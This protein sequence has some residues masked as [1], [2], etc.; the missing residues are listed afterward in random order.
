LVVVKRYPNRKL[1]NTAAKRYVSLDILADLIRQGED[2]QVLDHVTGD[3]VTVPVL[4]QIIAEQERKQGGFLPLPLLTGWIQAGGETLTSLRRAMAAQFDILRQVDEEIERR[5]ARL[6]SGGE[7]TEAEGQRLRE[8]LLARGQ[9]TLQ[10]IHPP[11]QMLESFRG[12]YGIPSRADLQALSGQIDAL[13]QQVDAL[14]APA[15]PEAGTPD[16][17]PP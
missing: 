14:R 8:L 17:T 7:L 5:L 6:V 11:E 1:Y 13:T 12:R 4:A 3:D 16:F 9:E 2:V 10:A 15:P